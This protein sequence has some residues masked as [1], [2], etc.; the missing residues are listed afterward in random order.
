MKKLLISAYS[1]DIGGIETA[2]ITLLKYLHNDYEITLVLEKKQGMFL[3]DV[4]NNVKIITYEISQKKIAII[5]KIDNFI[6][7]RKFIKANGNK[8]DCSICYA[9]YSK[10]CSFVAR[11]SSKSSILWVH[12]N[13]M[14]FFDGNVELYK[15]FFKELKIGEYKKIVFV[16]ELDKNIFNAYFPEYNKKTVFCNNLIDYK[17]IINKSNEA[18][19][20]FKINGVSDID[21]TVASPLETDK[22]LDEIK[23]KKA[24]NET[25]TDFKKEDVPTFINIGR[26]DEKQKKISRIIN[27]TRKLNL[28]G[29]KFNVI[30]IG[31]G[32]STKQYEEMCKDIKNIKFLG[33]KKNPYP[34]LKQSDCFLMSS[35]FEGYPVVLIESMILGTPIITTDVSDAKKD[36]DKKYGI[37]VENSEKGVYNGMKKFLD[38]YNEF[39]N[40]YIDKKTKI[41]KFNPEKFNEEIKNKVKD[42]IG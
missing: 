7:Q 33:A 39:K 6:R 40:G 26:H 38:N 34:Y 8:F 13:Y 27:S 35:K 18:I 20:D 17:T 9:T 23:R 10:P 36:I 28:Q 19:T 4:P 11:K 41:E 42:I 15:R 21:A 14:S 29:Y 37:V 24:N 3:K 22:A 2:L 16:S 30:I 32:S 5:R 25:I 31:K 1:L 12:N